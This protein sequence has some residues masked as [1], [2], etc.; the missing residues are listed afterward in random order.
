MTR[1]CLRKGLHL[2]W[3]GREYVI[4]QYLTTG[5]VLL[6]DVLT[7][8]LSTLKATALTQLLIQGELEFIEVAAKHGNQSHSQKGYRS[9]DFTQ[10]PSELR[11]ES[12]R[13]YRYIERVLSNNILKRTESNL[14]PIIDQVAIEIEDSQ[15]PSWL[16][17]WRW[18]KDYES[19]GRDIRSLVPKYVSKGN[20]QP[21]LNPEVRKI[22]SKVIEQVYLKPSQASGAD[23]YERVIIE[24]NQSNR[25]REA[26]GQDSL[27]IPNIAAIYRAIRQLDPYVKAVGRYGKRIASQMYD[28]VQKGQFPLRPLER[29]EIDHTKLPLFVVDTQTRMPIG[30]PWLT[31]AIDKYSGVVLG[32]YAS[33]EP[34]SYLSVMQCL[35][36]AISPKNYL[37][38][39]FK[40]VENTWD[41]Y[42]LPEVIVVD[43]GKEFYS[44]HFEDACL[45]LGI[46]IQYSPP[47]MPW[48][49]SAIERYFG[50]L[51]SQLLSD[52][53]GKTFSN[54]LQMSDYD[55]KKN[56]VISFEALQEILHIF[57]VDIY[58]QS[59][60]PELKS[61]RSKVW[62][63]AITEWTPALPPSNLE[64]KVL[65]GNITTRK[66][67][68]RGVEFEGLLYNS[69]ELARLRS[70]VKSTEK[71][72]VK[73]DPTDLSRIYVLDSRT[74]K[75]LEVPALSLEYTKGLTLW[76]HQVVKQLAR[77]E[78][79]IVDIVALSL[80]KEKIQLIVE[81]EWNSSKKGR[82]RS[83]MA[84][85][86]GIG[87]SGSGECSQ[88][89]ESNDNSSQPHSISGLSD[90]GRTHNPNPASESLPSP[91]LPQTSQPK[92]RSR[93]STKAGG[94]KVNSPAQPENRDSSTDNWQPDLLGWDVSIGL[95]TYP[96][97]IKPDADR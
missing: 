96:S 43:N 27:E 92:S 14:K 10:L 22:I 71:T 67:T 80:A 56:A 64:L 95:P 85:W 61:P 5:E 3:Q 55:P 78:A 7:N 15:P 49:K 97:Q 30:T 34:P 4:E 36:H 54:F 44:T 37:H 18:L 94:K 93:S 87:R 51:N 28:P 50:A 76:Q 47:K 60:H 17:L 65:M 73:Y 41:T 68:R 46:V 58:N 53:P 81:R 83:A 33:F 88:N 82:T 29:V 86:L 19:S 70:S 13:R 11:E 45:Q 26:I 6:Q 9:A 91:E 69:S 31:S 20:R 16:T 79:E 40:S 77:Q 62:K 35:L 42:G 21:R 25:L 74:H 2:T 63:L 52:A 1:I 89:Q 59:S 12:K 39:Q 75:F 48:Y 8:H 32:Y 23:V 66:V 84:R 57:I 38:S 72:T 90:L 24:I